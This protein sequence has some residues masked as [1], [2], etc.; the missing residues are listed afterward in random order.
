M[1]SR[2]GYWALCVSLFAF[3]LS[4]QAADAFKPAPD[5][6]WQEISDALG[7]QVGGDGTVS[8]SIQVVFDANSPYGAKLFKRWEATAPDTPV[9]WVP[10][11]YLGKDSAGRA[12]AI[13]GAKDS[14]A[15]L[16]ENAEHYDN[17]SH[18]GGYPVPSAFA[19]FPAKSLQ[20][21]LRPY[22]INTLGGYT[23]VTVF[24]AADGRVL[25]ADGLLSEAQIRQMVSQAAIQHPPGDAS[26]G[27]SGADAAAMQ[28]AMGD[29]VTELTNVTVTAAAAQPMPSGKTDSNGAQYLAYIAENAQIG[30]VTVNQAMLGTDQVIRNMVSLM[31]DNNTPS[32]KGQ[33]QS[34]S[35]HRAG[36]GT[37]N[38]TVV[39]YG[40]HCTFETG[41]Q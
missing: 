41:A 20:E 21:E 37:E 24:K 18:K 7:M 36:Q 33:C 27:Q 40:K 16:R 30:D 1:T 28:K 4:A 22:W 32:L 35:L 9:R 5:D 12:M 29:D 3:S 17:Q 10:I 38:P 26:N 15:A 31:G 14:T 34:V 2:Y 8:A 6:A 25:K 13:L 19:D 11:A 39:A 23:P